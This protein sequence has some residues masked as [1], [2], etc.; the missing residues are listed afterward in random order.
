[1]SNW[2]RWAGQMLDWH[3][4][5][6]AMG[7]RSYDPEL[8]RFIS[9]DPLGLSAG[10]NPYA[11]VGDSPTNGT[12][13]SGLEPTCTLGKWDCPYAMQGVGVAVESRWGGAAYAFALAESISLGSMWNSLAVTAGMLS[14]G[15]FGGFAVKAAAFIKKHLPHR[16][17]CATGVTESISLNG[18][19]SVGAGTIYAQGFGGN[20]EGGLA[21]GSDNT[22]SHTYALY[23][24]GGPSFG[25]GA[26]GGAEVSVQTGGVDD[27]VA[28]S[29]KAGGGGSIELEGSYGDFGANA[30]FLNHKF[31]GTGFNAG[32]GAGL[33]VNMTSFGGHTGCFAF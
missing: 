24:H 21:I 19:Y 33:F 7:A 14:Q 29:F 20:L 25:Y 30:V 10:I 16:T 12:D 22:H 4:G 5:L 18:T 13:P 11:Y 31:S 23:W 2:L 1:V 28:S 26:E 3:E 15:D 8:G 27:L 6:Y 32:G 17:T 9:E